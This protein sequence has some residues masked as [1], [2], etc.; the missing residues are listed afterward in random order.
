MTW[1][2]GAHPDFLGDATLQVVKEVKEKDGT[3]VKDEDG[4]VVEEVV[5]SFHLR[6]EEAPGEK[7]VNAHRLLT[8]H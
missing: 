4:K 6:G 3:V 1:Q 7:Q 2:R 5:K 8:C